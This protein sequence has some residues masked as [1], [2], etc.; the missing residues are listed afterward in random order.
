MINYSFEGLEEVVRKLDGVILQG[1]L[2]KFF[3]RI[4][5]S[6]QA[7]IQELTP[8]DTGRL[9]GSINTTVDTASVPLWAK[10]STAVLYANYVELGTRPHFPPPGALDTWA[11][12]HGF[13]NGFV[14]ARIIAMKGTKARYMFRDGLEK[15][16][17]SFDGFIRTAE[18]DIKGA[19]DKK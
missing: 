16:K 12:R 2:K 11:R 9:R 15:A 4:G 10:V 1:P 13:E 18:S 8:V 14:V 17:A 5:R 3:E 19:W 7:R 6:A